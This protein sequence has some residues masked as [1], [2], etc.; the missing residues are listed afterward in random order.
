MRKAVLFAAIGFAA[1]VG[2]GP[3]GASASAAL[4]QDQIK[5]E[6]EKTYGV[7]VL[8]MKEIEVAGKPAYAVTVM[9]KGGNDNRAFQVNTILVDP[10]SGHLVSAYRIMPDGYDF[11]DVLETNPNKQP[12]DLLARRGNHPWP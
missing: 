8:R 11:S 5:A 4:S 1:C 3:P 6:I 2:M 10:E 7:S 12:S 9:N